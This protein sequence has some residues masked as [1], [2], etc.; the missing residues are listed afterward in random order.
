[1]ILKTLNDQNLL[2]KNNSESLQYV[3]V[4]NLYYFY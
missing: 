2:K 4:G 3:L 1:M